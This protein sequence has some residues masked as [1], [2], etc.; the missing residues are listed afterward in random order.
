MLAS[1]TYPYF[2]EDPIGWYWGMFDITLKPEVVE[3]GRGE[4]LVFMAVHLLL[5]AAIALLIAAIVW[6]GV[7][8]S[9]RRKGT[10]DA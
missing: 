5:I 6:C 2:S 10:S 9:G 1:R 8:F 3:W 4:H 7:Y